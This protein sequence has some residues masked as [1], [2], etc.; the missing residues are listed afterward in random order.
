MG[1]GF[2]KPCSNAS[3]QP[4]FSIS[5]E[6]LQTFI[7][8]PLFHFNYMLSNCTLMIRWNFCRS[9]GCRHAPLTKWCRWMHLLFHHDRDFLSSSP[10]LTYSCGLCLPNWSCWIINGHPYFCTHWWHFDLSSLAQ[11]ESLQLLTRLESEC[12]RCAACISSR[13][14]AVGLKDNWATPSKRNISIN[15]AIFMVMELGQWAWSVFILP[16]VPEL[17][18]VGS[19][20]CIVPCCLSSISSI[21]CLILMF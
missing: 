11:I 10:S 15:Y 17:F 8:H 6:S 14:T 16:R 1:G 19:E 20:R 13:T 12:W 18:I 7:N 3:S 21:T 4:P 9:S 5:F 2:G